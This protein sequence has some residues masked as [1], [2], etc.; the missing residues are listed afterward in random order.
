[1]KFEEVFSIIIM[2]MILKMCCFTSQLDDFKYFDKTILISEWNFL[3]AWGNISGV[4]GI[5]AKK[6]LTKNYIRKNHIC[7]LRVL[8]I[9]I[10][11]LIK[12]LVYS[13]F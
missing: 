13:I 12:I 11:F 9:L 1:M 3:L 8:L 10:V 2:C 6:Y 4:G 7:L 5:N